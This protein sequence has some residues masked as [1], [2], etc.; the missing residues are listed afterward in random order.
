M[1]KYFV[2]NGHGVM[3]EHSSGPMLDAFMAENPHL[4]GSGSTK[5]KYTDANTA[6]STRQGKSKKRRDRSNAMPSVE[7]RL[8][9][10]FD[11]LKHIS[12]NGIDFPAELL[13]RIDEIQSVKTDNPLD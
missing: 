2:H 10:I 12:E 1:S 11:A 13:T 8:D 3:C 4:E 6:Q 9:V 7:D 5:K